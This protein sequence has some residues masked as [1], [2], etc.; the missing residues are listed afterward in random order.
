LK[1]KIEIRRPESSRGILE[2]TEPNFRNSLKHGIPIAMGTD[3]GMTYTFFGD[4][5]IEL[6]HMVNWGMDEDD[7]IMAGTFV[8]AKEL[9]ILNKVGTME[10]GK[11]ADLL[12][13][14]EDPL[15]NIE[16]L[17]DPEQIVHIMING[18]FIEHLLPNF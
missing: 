13:L 5:P 4:N 1:K 18:R 3:S 2:E 9:N 7:A 10:V 12:V 8:A 15:E 14:N 16:V 11:Y 17:T 6:V